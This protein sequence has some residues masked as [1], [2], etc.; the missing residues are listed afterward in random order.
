MTVM[1]QLDLGGLST[2]TNLHIV[3]DQTVKVAVNSTN[4]NAQVSVGKSY[5]IAGCSVTALYFLNEN[6]TYTANVQ[7]IATD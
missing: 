4:A 3:T 1:Q 5:M 6:T 2:A 7:V